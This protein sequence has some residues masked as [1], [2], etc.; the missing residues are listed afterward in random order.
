MG[1]KTSQENY[2]RRL[3]LPEQKTQKIQIQDGE[4]I[5]KNATNL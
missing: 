2:N 5:K 1:R 3:I 4:L